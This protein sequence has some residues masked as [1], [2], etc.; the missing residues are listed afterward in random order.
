MTENQEVKSCPIINTKLTRQ[1]DTSPTLEG[2]WEK[3]VKSIINI[4]KL[5]IRFFNKDLAKLHYSKDRLRY[6]TMGDLYRL[7]AWFR[8][9][10]EISGK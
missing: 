4:Q 2:V 8:K 5:A 9:E 6:L 7:E 3:K 1:D 10:I